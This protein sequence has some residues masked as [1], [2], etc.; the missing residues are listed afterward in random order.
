MRTNWRLRVIV[1]GQKHDMLLGSLVRKALVLQSVVESCSDNFS[2]HAERGFALKSHE[3][4]LA[5]IAQNVNL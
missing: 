1:G 3:E 5:K 2:V 4:E